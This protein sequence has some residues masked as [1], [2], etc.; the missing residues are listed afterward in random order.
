V[1]KASWNAFLQ[2]ISRP[3]D[4]RDHAATTLSAHALVFGRYRAT[5]WHSRLLRA[6]VRPAGLRPSRRS[7]VLSKRTKGAEE[8][9]GGVS[10]FRRN[11]EMGYERATR[12][13]VPRTARRVVE[14]GWELR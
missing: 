5:G 12:G 11:L 7:T 1:S 10:Q 2:L 13:V 14:G 3:I 4:P 8:G 6:L 9:V